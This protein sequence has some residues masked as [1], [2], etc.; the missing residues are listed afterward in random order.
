MQVLWV[1]RMVWGMAL[2]ISALVGTHARGSDDSAGRWFGDQVMPKGIVRGVN[3]DR[4]P[5]PRAVH[6][7]MVQ[8]V[9]GLAAKAVN[10]GRGDEMVWV[11]SENAD[12]QAWW[13][14]AQ[15]REPKCEVRGTFGPWELVERYKNSGVIKGYVLYRL[16]RSKGAG[17]EHRAGM[18]C[19]V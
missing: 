15:R 18:D 7:M 10:E 13:A 8:S 4:Y 12:T 2:F 6:Q 17:N 19:S 16:D 9:A 1:R 14:A 11:G 3:E 5:E